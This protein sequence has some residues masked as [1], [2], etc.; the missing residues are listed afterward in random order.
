[1]AKSP[2]S[3][4]SRVSQMAESSSSSAEG[5]GR[6]Y[7]HNVS[8]RMKPLQVWGRPMPVSVPALHH[9][10]LYVWLQA[11]LFGVYR[12]G[13]ANFRSTVLVPSI[14]STLDALPERIGKSAAMFGLSELHDCFLRLSACG[15]CMAELQPSVCK[16][17]G[18][19]S[20]LLQKI[21]RFRFPAGKYH[22]LNSP[23]VRTK[24]EAAVL[25]DLVRLWIG[26]QSRPA[27]SADAV[28][29]S[30]AASG[31]RMNCDIGILGQGGR[32]TS[33]WCTPDVHACASTYPQRASLACT[34]ST[35]SY[36][37]SCARCVQTHAIIVPVQMQSL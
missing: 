34:A 27:Q 20:H 21:I 30:I 13:R 36:S 12:K 22:T 18:C 26:L 11:K 33:A 10:G 6:L 9:T 8:G 5:I 19:L 14:Y 4:D 16:L 15:P 31:Q 7:F 37:S 23:V 25:H 17:H 35:G 24:L 1:M 32:A 2:S 3:S 29:A 28:L